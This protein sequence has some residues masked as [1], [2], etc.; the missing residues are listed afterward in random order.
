M[1]ILQF[2]SAPAECPHLITL[3]SVISHWSDRGRLVEGKVQQFANMESALR[4]GVAAATRA[5]AVRVCR[6]RGSVDADYWEE[7]VTVAKY[8]PRAS[9][10]SQP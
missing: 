2:R 3:Y 6:V 4:A 10:L 1:A 8:G 7:A 5:P 9:E